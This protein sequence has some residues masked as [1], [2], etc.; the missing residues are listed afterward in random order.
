VNAH[1]EISRVRGTPVTGRIGVG[2][3]VLGGRHV[4]DA[5]IAPTNNVLNA[6]ASVRYR[7]VEVGFDMYNV[8]GLKYAD[9]EEYYVSNWSFK[10]GQNPASAMTHIVAAPPRTALATLSLYF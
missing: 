7:L 1:G 2:Y 5:I 9:D 10:P 4:N 6:L 3:T 8:L